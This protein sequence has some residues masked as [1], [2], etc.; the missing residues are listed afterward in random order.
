MAVV[1]ITSVVC[2]S[3]MLNHMEWKSKAIMGVGM[4]VPELQAP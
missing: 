4:K 1:L 2:V 3:S